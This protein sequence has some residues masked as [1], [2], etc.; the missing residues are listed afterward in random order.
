MRNELPILSPNQNRVS[1]RELARTLLTGL[2]A[3]VLPPSISPL[4]PIHRHLLDGILL[5]SADEALAVGAYQP[6]FLSIAQLATV[7]K[8]SE[9]VIPGSH[10]AQ[11]A[12]FIDLLLSVESSKHQEDFLTSLSALDEAASKAFHKATA[13]LDKHQLQQLLEA[14]S[15]KDSADYHHFENLKQWSTGAYYSSEMGMREL[16]WTSDRVFPT[17]PGC[18]HA[19]NHS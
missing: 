1:R 11:S 18:A 19:E 2:A 15:S 4:H 10:K 3:G 13:A 16:G 5:D 9:A 6:A 8:L 14:A 12:E 17:Y 7:D